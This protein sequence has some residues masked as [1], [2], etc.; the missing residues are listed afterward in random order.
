[1]T[2]EINK[3]KIETFEER[4]EDQKTLKSEL[5][6]LSQRV[7]QKLAETV[8]QKTRDLSRAFAKEKSYIQA[9]THSESLKCKA[10]IRNETGTLE[11]RLSE[12]LQNKIADIKRI[13]HGAESHTNTDIAELHDILNTARKEIDGLAMQLD[14]I[15]LKLNK[16]TIG[17]C[18]LKWMHV[19]TTDTNGVVTFGSKSELISAAMTGS[20]VR[21]QLR[22]YYFTSVQNLQTVGDN[23]CGQALFHISK[24]SWKTFQENAYWWSLNVCTTGRVQM[25]RYYVGNHVSPSTN[26]ETWQIQWFVRENGPS[27]YKHTSGGTALNG[28]LSDLITNVRRGAD[29]R[30]VMESLGYTAKMDNVQISDTGN[31]VVGQAVW[32]VSQSLAP[33]NIEFQGNDY[34]WFSNFATDGGHYM[35]RWRIGEHTS[36]GATNENRQIT[37]YTDTCWQLAYQHDSAGNEFLGSLDKLRSAA[38]RGH[39]VKLMIGDTSV[40]PEQVIVRG[41]HVNAMIISKVLKANSNI[42][43]FDSTGVWD[44]SMVTTTG[45]QTTLK[46]R[47]GEATETAD[48]RVITATAVTWFIDTRPWRKVLAHDKFGTVTSGS[49]V[50]LTDAVKLGARVRYIMR[51]DGSDSTTLQE[52]DYIAIYGA[53]VGANH[54]R[55]VSIEKTPGSTVELRFQKNPY[56][57]FTIAATTG[58]VDMS[59]WTVGEHTNRGHNSQTAA[60]EWFVN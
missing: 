24:A 30:G 26:F 38:E 56:W 2:V 25:M 16:L 48:S 33:P 51:F 54:V 49:K 15:M 47:V 32:H 50:A 6:E 41:G 12:N 4:L 17:S 34:W 57:W 23:I 22:D 58:Y 13:L 55:S 8:Q 21:I 42:K 35:S 45:T 46:L 53:D 3:N 27:E 5:P 43:E 18:H 36:V 20:D 9:W 37:W 10:D 60:I 28:Y 59:R 1:M 44:W 29:V 14:N 11:K 40:E 7:E 39:R 19:L 31:L 52:A